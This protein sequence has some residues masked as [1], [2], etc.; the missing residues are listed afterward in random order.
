MKN[1]LNFYW[2]LWFSW[3][4]SLNITLLLDVTLILYRVGLLTSKNDRHLQCTLSAGTYQIDG[5]NAGISVVVL[6]KQLL[7]VKTFRCN[8]YLTN[9][10]FTHLWNLVLIKKIQHLRI[11][12]NSSFTHLLCLILFWDIFPH[13]SFLWDTHI[14]HF[15]N[16]SCTCQYNIL[17]SQFL[18][19]KFL[20]VWYSF[21]RNII[22]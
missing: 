20:L 1:I 9:K 16:G 13:F 6:L 2:N 12:I 8:L 11:F 14:T 5:F 18:L 17:V 10:F 22:V 19:R 15:M 4:L 7:L 21:E 3:N